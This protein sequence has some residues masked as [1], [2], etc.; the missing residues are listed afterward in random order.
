MRLQLPDSLHYPITVTELLKQPNDKVDRF[1]PLFSY[2]YKTTVTEGNRFGDEI[3]V[4]KTFPSRFESPIDGVLIRWQIQKGSVIKTKEVDVAEIDEPCSHS[5]QV[6]GMCAN[7]GKDMTEVSYNTFS[8]SQRA[9][10]TM[11]HDNTSVTIS[12]DEATRVEQESKRRLLKARKLSLVVD[13]DQ[14]V[15]Q[16]TVD[17]TVA[18]W[19]EDLQNPNYHAVKDVGKF[20]LVDEI[21]GGRVCWYF[22]KM[23]PGLKEFL[24][25][26]SKLYELHVYTMGT[27]AYAQCVMEIV[28]HDHRLFGDR[29]L[30]RDESGSQ[31]E[32][33]LHRLFPVDTKMVVIIDD[34]GDVWKW[35]DNLIKVTP[36]DFFVGI[37]DINSSFL[38]KSV[39]IIPSPKVAQVDQPG[40]IE[41]KDES[42]NAI[43][44]SQGS[45]PAVASL[46]DESTLDQLVAM[47]TADDP[48]V[49]ASQA[50]RQNQALTAQ[51]EER[52]LLQKQQQLDR[53]DNAA[54]AAAL[55]L[56][57]D[58]PGH[59]TPSTHA[60]V[61]DQAHRH[62]LLQDNDTELIYLE[63]N[64]TE[65]H[66]KFFE[67]Y[68]KR[69]A[70]AAGG[71]VA[72][73][74]GKRPRRISSMNSESADLQIVPDIKQIMP[75]RKK[76]VLRGVVIVFSGVVP[77]ETNIMTSDIAQWTMSFGAEIRVKI[78]GDTTHL[79]SAK[80]R[81]AKVR[82][83]ASRPFIKIVN[84][85]WLFDSII[86][87]QRKD[88]TPYLIHVD[89]EDR[90]QYY[91]SDGSETSG[92]ESSYLDNRIDDQNLLSSSED[93]NGE[94]EAENSEVRQK[95]RLKI[96][97]NEE[98][99]SELDY[100]LE[101][102]LPGDLD[103][104]LS[105][106]EGFDK[107]EWK[108]ELAEFLG[109]DDESDD[110]SIVSDSSQKSEPG[111][112]EGRATSQKFPEDA[113]NSKKRA[114]DP[115]VDAEDHT[116]LTN[117][118]NT[119]EDAAS[120]SR[121]AKRQRESA[122]RSSRLKHVASILEPKIVNSDS[123]DG[124]DTANL[125]TTPKPMYNHTMPNSHP[126]PK[127]RP[128]QPNSPQSRQES[129]SL[130][131]S[132]YNNT[133]PSTISISLPHPNITS[134]INNAT[135]DAND[136]DTDHEN[137]DLFEGGTD[138]ATFDH[139]M[140]DFDNQSVG[141]GQRSVGP[142]ENGDDDDELARE[143]E[144]E[145]EADMEAG[146]EAGMEAEIQMLDADAS[147]A[148]PVGV[149]NALGLD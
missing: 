79:V 88:E 137:D 22:I 19:Q 47:D 4:E 129:N 45:P 145:M 121:L 53:E 105:P 60:I 147:A 77:M 39:P 119:R 141:E 1:A 143:L 109:S 10:I 17:P 110:E 33:T 69:V 56:L 78:S 73:L 34:R 68:E 122:Q 20:Q 87:W 24:E 125:H 8:N 62:N 82:R 140:K 136:T 118:G 135:P 103:G 148:G 25:N 91:T 52:P 55:D 16:A 31:K 51:L 43:E 35:S 70:G 63:Q 49:L 21:P 18:Q 131:T 61:L 9:K 76:Q 128:S 11:I 5:I 126:I 74:R 94:Y 100:D 149:D 75:H 123:T 28:D 59:E 132:I 54:A 133:N 146:M 95:I 90:T 107:G 102:L 27:R 130:H 36:Y 111:A 116:S 29:I 144:A 142:S 13:L 127:M 38:P 14:T 98:T 93:D 65:I 139:L 12:K 37:G 67:V 64:L 120:G 97:V 23:R 40:E 6:G 2:Y 72:A 71:R 46:D 84:T 92:R 41:L 81:T 26:I 117:G 7:C 114:R 48:T 42:D 80:N 138:E 3:Q 83:A 57:S 96:R 112:R 89:P 85:Q 108:D 30:S 104:Q 86:Q 115:S 32:K 106:V 124:N 113:T 44:P 66:Q 134:L 50:V 101:G 15:I 58:Y 99:E